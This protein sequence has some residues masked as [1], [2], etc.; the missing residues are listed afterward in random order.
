MLF[1]FMLMLRNKNMEA[2]VIMVIIICPILIYISLCIY[3]GIVRW[4]IGER[5]EHAAVKTI[6]LKKE[7]FTRMEVNKEIEINGKLF[8]VKSY[9]IQN[10]EV[11]FKRL[12]MKM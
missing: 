8:V 10:N 9:D 2:S 7:A 4:Q 5:L 3:K 1:N 12:L 6:R 11:I